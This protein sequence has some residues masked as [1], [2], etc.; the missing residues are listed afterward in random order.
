MSECYRS[1]SNPP[2]GPKCEN[3]HTARKAITPP[4]PD[5]THVLIS[6]HLARHQ[7]KAD[8]SQLPARTVRKQWS[9]GPRLKHSLSQNGNG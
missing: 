1:W 7:G 3:P 4:A 9:N 2:A 6:P 5:N 8:C